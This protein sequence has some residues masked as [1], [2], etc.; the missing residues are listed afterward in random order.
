MRAGRCVEQRPAPRQL[1]HGA[2][3]SQFRKDVDGLVDERFAEL[4]DAAAQRNARP[5]RD[6]ADPV[7]R[8]VRAGE[9]QIAW[10][11]LADEIADEVAACG[12]NDLVE[13]VLRVKMPAHRVERVAV[14]PGLE[15]LAAANLDDFQIRFHLRLLRSSGV[16]RRCPFLGR[17]A[18]GSRLSVDGTGSASPLPPRIAPRYDTFLTRPTRPAPELGR[19]TV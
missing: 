19:I 4:D 15:R 1:E 18:A 3:R 8:E 7:V 17:L 5:P 9:D 6:V 11:K 12:F 13:L 14:R 16:S 10:R 2:E